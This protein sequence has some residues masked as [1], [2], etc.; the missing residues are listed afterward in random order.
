[1]KKFIL[2]LATLF[3][4]SFLLIGMVQALSVTVTAVPDVITPGGT[5]AITVTSDGAATVAITVRTPSGKLYT[6]SLT[7]SAAGS[8]TV[9]FPDDFSKASSI[10]SG[11]YNVYVY[12]GGTLIA[13]ASFTVPPQMNNPELP[14]GT[15]GAT[16]AMMAGLGLF[17]VKKRR[18]K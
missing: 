6:R 15:I 2:P 12:L 7:F 17:V 9:N 13:R 18:Q 4:L 16:A 14:I 10:E 3:I 11:V 8:I 1:M 5:T